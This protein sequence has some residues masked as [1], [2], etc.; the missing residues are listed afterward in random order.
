MEL[1]LVGHSKD[2]AQAFEIDIFCTDIG[3]GDQIHNRALM[4][5]DNTGMRLIG[6]VFHRR[7]VPMVPARYSAVAIHSLLNDRP[8]AVCG[9]N[10]SMKIELKAVSD[11][12]VVDACRQTTGSEPREYPSKLVAS[13]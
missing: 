13:A 11:C 2:R 9:N 4:L 10:E 1:A 12:I 7:R 6:K 5:A 3:S 8:F